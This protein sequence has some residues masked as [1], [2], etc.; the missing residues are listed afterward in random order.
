[1]ITVYKA[2]AG[3][4]KTFNLVKEYLKFLLGKKNED[5]SY[6][7]DKHPKDKHGAILAI[8]FTNKATEEMKNRIIDELDK[9]SYATSESPYKDELCKIFSTSEAE[10]RNS[11]QIAMK[12]MLHDYS[13]FN[14]STIDA[15][16]QLIL[17]TFA[18]EVELSGNYNVELNDDYA[19]AVGISGLKQELH[20]SGLSAKNRILRQWIIDFMKAKI[21]EGK[22]WDIFRLPTG[23]SSGSDIYS[24]AHDLSKETVKR[25]IDSLAC[26]LRDNS[27]ITAFKAAL[28]NSIRKNRTKIDDACAS[29]RAVTA[30]CES[31]DFY[32]RF[33][34]KF[35]GQPDDKTIGKICEAEG[36]P[37]KWF[38]T[39]PL[40]S[41]SADIIDGIDRCI[42]Q[43]REAANGIDSYKLI[44]S[45]LYFLGLLGDI[46]ANISEFTKENNVIMLSDTNEMLKKIINEDDAPFIYERVGIR[47][48]NFLI[49]EFQDT[50]RM[51][52]ENLEP[53]IRNSI[54]EGN[55]NLIIGDVKQSI[56]RFRN[57]DPTILK[58]DIYR[59]FG[60]YINDIGTSPKENTNW[61]SAT[62]IVR[63]NNTFFTLLAKRLGMDDIY[64]N[65]VQQPAAK[66][67]GNPGYVRF[68]RIGDENYK[69]TILDRTIADIRSMLARGY[70][71]NDI[72]ILV[73]KKSEGQDVITRILDDGRGKA[74][75]EQINVVSEEALLIRKSPAVK[76]IIA[77]LAALDSQ[78]GYRQCDD[79]KKQKNIA[80]IIKQFE[81]NLSKGKNVTEAIS[82]AMEN[83]GGIDRA[84]IVGD[85]AALSLTSLI[86]R[87]L[88]T[89]LSKEM[90]AGQTPFIQAFVD[91]ATDF[92]ERYGSD[93]H[94]FMKYWDS[95]GKNMTISSPDNIRAVS[96]MTIHKSK[97]LEFPCVIIPFCNWD[98]EPGR[99][100]EWVES[101]KIDL[102]DIPSDCIPPVIPVIR[103]KK[104]EKT[105]F[106]K[107]FAEM[108][109][110]GTLDSLNKTYVAFTRAGEELIAYMPEN[111]QGTLGSLILETAAAGQSAIEGI[112][113]GS[114]E[115]I[116]DRL[117]TP[118]EFFNGEILEIG[119]PTVPPDK[120]E[121]E[122]GAQKAEMPEY[123]VINRPGLWKFDVPDMVT[124]PHGS[125][126][127]KGIVMHRIMCK[128]KHFDGVDSA[129]RQF[130]AKGAITADEA[131]EFAGIIKQ[132]L[133]NPQ[134][135]EWF[136]YG[137]R[138]ISERPVCDGN[139]R[140]YRPDRVV[141]TPD[142]RTIVI[143]Y[144]FGEKEDKRY[145]SQVKNY[146]S[147]I[148]KCGF[149]N[150]EG[151]VWYVPEDIIR[152]V[153]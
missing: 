62:N 117:L 86:D 138:I 77:I 11:A 121:K 151:Y 81:S 3:S 129:I 122:T 89:N 147:I 137:N 148:G 112:T 71:Q 16:F 72:A 100:M 114:K 6:S 7:L 18:Y 42:K 116:S 24:F 44:L 49:D 126:R 87:I 35:N 140:I 101:E 80:V 141:V 43:I 105:V 102:K 133:R 2:S 23:Q 12:Q 95:T 10:L 17:R 134:A 90:I 59:S 108:T 75:E 119:E 60:K 20:E 57:S 32:R 34:E 85:T 109:Y 13:N 69:Q 52:W 76:T 103:S 21:D 115:N 149:G 120:Q 107:I 132:G 128:I 58:D 96:V 92:E 113:A 55:D 36:R 135:R 70:R 38:K 5:G 106:G 48:K 94:Q 67:A 14:I 31:G 25:N 9:L 66:N 8:T 97:G 145:L 51:Q 39:K 99:Q 136:D 46:S 19:I 82:E 37:E 139:G 150:T 104:A 123:R 4:G 83:S 79:T 45:N 131:E 142:G 22:S 28:Q 78:S 144:K 56:Y 93:L 153:I 15:F 124:E 74:E 54:S 98:L 1:M 110:A 91:L 88:Q 63:W 47:L 40:K 111:T 68:E 127:F 61:R 152:K 33:N 84:Q 41:V 27:K 118:N 50:S 143:D 73:N 29:F 64:S 130:A 146:M 26:Y 65:V 30:Q 125:N 53:L